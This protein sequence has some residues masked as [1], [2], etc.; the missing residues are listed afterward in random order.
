M[1]L[2]AAS[3]YPTTPP[4]DVHMWTWNNTA[5]QYWCLSRHNFADGSHA[6]QVRNYYTGLCLDVQVDSPIG[7]GDPV[8]L[9][10]CKGSGDSTSESQLW[11]INAQGSVTVPGGSATGYYFQHD[12]TVQC[13]DVK[14]QSVVDGAAL[15]TWGCK[16]GGNQLF[17]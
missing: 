11:V 5:N 12:D 13:L 16:Y 6:W 15:Q 17:Y 14:D 10:S 2:D 7:N 4:G 9:W 8:W 1:V 3:P